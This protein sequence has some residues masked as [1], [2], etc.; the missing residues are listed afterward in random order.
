MGFLSSPMGKGVAEANLAKGEASFVD[1]K[2]K[3]EEGRGEAT[4][5]LL[6][7]I[8]EKVQVLRLC[9]VLLHAN[10]CRL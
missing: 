4:E 7:K 2:G 9:T 3:G 6:K 10:L 1:W 8:K 5:T